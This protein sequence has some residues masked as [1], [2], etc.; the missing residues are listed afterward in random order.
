MRV[1]FFQPGLVHKRFN[2]NFSVVDRRF[3]V[4]PDVG[5]ATAAAVAREAGAQVR[6]WD[7]YATGAELGEVRREM[8]RWRPD[9]LAAAFHSVPAVREVLAWGSVLRRDLDV[10][11][12]LGGHETVRYGLDVMQTAPVDYLLQGASGRTLP[13]LLD[14]IE[15]D[16]GYERVPGLMWRGRNAVVDNG[17]P[18]AVS[19]P[20]DPWPARDLL[21]LDRYQS[22]LTQR[23]HYTVLVTARGCPYSCAFCAMARS[24]YHPRPVDDV[25]REMEH[26]IDDLGIHEFDLFD[27][28][29]LHQRDRVL[30]LCVEIS[31]RKLEMEWA[32]RSRIDLVDPELLRAL[33]D[34]GCRRIYY[35]IESGA[36]AIL[37]R[38]HKHIDL[39]SVGRALR[40]TSDVGIQPLGFFQVGHPGETIES[41]RRTIRFALDL[42]LDYAQFM[43]TIAKPGSDLEQLLMDATGRDPW[44]EYVRGERSDD[45]L[46]TPWHDLAPE[47]VDGLV[48]EAYLRF[49]ARPRIA[50]GTVTRSR[51]IW[52]LR[53]Y[54]RV[55]FEMVTRDAEG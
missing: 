43:R 25:I 17:A 47:T 34:A 8:S 45:R 26:C 55:A 19:E 35:G 10:P 50:G 52:E 11:L 37:Q 16:S 53:R 5:L 36:P 49:Y 7:A 29:L 20:D 32:C 48:R 23:R 6:I 30:D 54:L 28:L 41:A 18:T 33:A 1:A 15:T 13:P 46:P 12:L 22:Y 39:D 9:L 2:E 51:S 27:P 38:I 31:A 4:F 44:R 14:A 40:M 21:P 3:G 42:P 24:G